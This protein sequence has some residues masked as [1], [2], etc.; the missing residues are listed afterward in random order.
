MGRLG[1]PAGVGST[2]AILRTAAEL[3][4]RRAGPLVLIAVIFLVPNALLGVLERRAAESSAGSGPDSPL[5]ADGGAAGASADG[6]AAD[7]GG[8]DAGPSAASPSPGSPAG[9]DGAPG[10]DLFAGINARDAFESL[11]WLFIGS[12]FTSML[13]AAVARE[14]G[15]AVAGRD[16]APLRSVGYGFAHVLGLGFLGILAAAWSLVLLLLAAP[17]FM[18]L[19]LLE[20]VL[21]T[22][23]V[24]ALAVLLAIPVA[25][26][27][28]TLASLGI[29][30]FVLEGRRGMGALI[31]VWLLARGEVRH[32]F[33]T[34]LVLLLVG[35]TASGLAKALETV[36]GEGV[37]PVLAVGVLV[38]PFAALVAFF[39][40]LDLRARKERV[41]LATVQ[42]D[43]SRNAP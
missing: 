41:T 35:V 39:L 15:L 29:P 30:V 22:G 18:V 13:A 14:A 37:A 20:R 6:G 21:S 26:V 7:G 9:K 3:Y 31:R 17:V 24:S 34:A 19:S 40:Y 11:V 2:G 10:E 32:V 33:A 27:F 5:L 4:R 36:T 42:D 25:L 23:V 38:A 12:L 28:T 16:P 43:L 1:P 8:S